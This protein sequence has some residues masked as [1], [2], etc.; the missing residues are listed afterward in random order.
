M[1]KGMDPN[2]ALM[3]PNHQGNQCGYPSGT[4]RGSGQVEAFHGG[5]TKPLDLGFGGGIHGR[6]GG[7]DHFYQRG[8]GYDGHPI[9]Q[10]G[11]G[12]R[13]FVDLSWVLS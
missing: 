1:R 4:S 6:R 11:G 7:A 8:R 12:S 2:G 9:P 3:N 5:F 13:A 10:Q